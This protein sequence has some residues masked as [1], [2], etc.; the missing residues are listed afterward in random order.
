MGAE[1]MAATNWFVVVVL[2]TI[3]MER[4][5]LLRKRDRLEPATI[6]I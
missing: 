5:L 2:G 3:W 1:L 4:R 6:S